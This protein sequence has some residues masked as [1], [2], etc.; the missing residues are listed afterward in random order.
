MSELALEKL[1]VGLTSFDDECLKIA[2]GGSYGS[3]KELF[4]VKCPIS[5]RSVDVFSAMKSLTRLDVSGV[6]RL[7]SDEL[8]GLSGVEVLTGSCVL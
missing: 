6:I 5:S 1:N 2:V 4:L 8:G 3:M 7:D